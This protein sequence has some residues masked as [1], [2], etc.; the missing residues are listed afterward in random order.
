MRQLELLELIAQGSDNAQIAATLGLSEKTVRNHITGIFA[1][2]EVENRS[3][4]IVRARLGLRQ[5]RALGPAVTDRPCRRPWRGAGPQPS[6][7]GPSAR[8]VWA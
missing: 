3:Q 4:A 8:T 6:A 2:L 1:K 7:C 5:A